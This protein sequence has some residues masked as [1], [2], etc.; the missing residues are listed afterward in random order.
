MAQ[1]AAD[2]FWSDKKLCKVVESAPT[3]QHMMKL[4][5]LFLMLALALPAFAQTSK[6]IVNLDKQGLAGQ[7]Y[8]PVAFF[9]DQ[10]PV[11]R[12]VDLQSTYHGAIYLFATAEHKALFDASPEKYEPAFG[13]YCAYGVSKGH[14]APV[15][16]EAFQIVDGRLLM[17]N[18]TR[19]RDGFNQD[20]KG[21]LA[22][23]DATWPE[24]VEKSG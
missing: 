9:T 10:K 15:K 21:N 4:S 8:D 18:S 20:Q 5:F 17:Q 13:G 23:A 12:T 16:V 22:R 2:S 3:N 14:L 19:V 11:K 1:R 7:G 6:A 24:L